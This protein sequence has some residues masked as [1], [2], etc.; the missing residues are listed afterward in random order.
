M[1]QPNLNDLI[2][3]VLA[4]ISA[5]VLVSLGRKNSHGQDSAVARLLSEAH[6]A[7]SK[8]DYEIEQYALNKALSL[9]ESGATT[10]V[11]KYSS[12]LVS[13]AESY[14]RK[15]KFSQARDACKRM[16]KRWNEILQSRDHARMIDIDYFAATADFGS[17]I[18]DVAEFYSKVIEAKKQMYGP[19]HTEVINSMLL[20]SRLLAKSGDRRHAEEMETSA[21][22]LRD[23]SASAA[24]NKAS[25]SQSADSTESQAQTVDASVIES[26]DRRDWSGE[27]IDASVIESIDRTE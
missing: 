21:T 15:G 4:S 25:A 14:T 2:I 23:G 24:V 9:L 6:L 12:C 26:T 27:A 22:Q 7:R 19:K 5:I 13:L 3:V 17:G 1:S 11:T 18:N 16:L 10:D 20:Y 8:G